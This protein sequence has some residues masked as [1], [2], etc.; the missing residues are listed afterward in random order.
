MGIFTR[1]PPSER[2][3]TERRLAQSGLPGLAPLPGYG[4]RAARYIVMDDRGRQWL[5]RWEL[6]HVIPPGGRTWQQELEDEEDR[7]MREDWEA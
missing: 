2:E 3:A 6:A 5:D 7:I 4:G 1:R